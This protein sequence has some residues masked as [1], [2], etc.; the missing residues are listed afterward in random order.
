MFLPREDQKPVEKL[1]ELFMRLKEI[2]NQMASGTRP[3][4]DKMRSMTQMHLPRSVPL[5][6]VEKSPG[7]VLLENFF[8]H[9]GFT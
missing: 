9:I 4:L 7:D 6:Q 8:C 3:L 1:I 5:T 2:L